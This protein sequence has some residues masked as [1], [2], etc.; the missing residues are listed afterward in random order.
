MDGF[1]LYHYARKGMPLPRPIEPRPVN[2]ES[3]DVI[4]WHGSEHEFRE[5]EKSLSTEEKAAVETAL[6]SVESEPTV[7]DAPGAEAADVGEGAVPTAFKVAMTV[8]GGTYVRSLVHDLAHAV[9]SAGH[10]VTLTRTRQGRFALKPEG[11]TEY[12]CVPWDVFARAEKEQ[13]ERDADGWTEWERAVLD[14]LELVE[15]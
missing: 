6:S 3:F 5:P 12:G 15:R 4:E 13:G 1:P 8:S 11:D 9:G 7:A 10:V 14:R 2:V